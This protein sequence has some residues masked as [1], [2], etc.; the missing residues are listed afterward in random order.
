M[1]RSE[2]QNEYKWDLSDLYPDNAEWE[3]E[4]SALNKEIVAVL[5][6]KGRLAA[7]ENLLQCLSLCDSLGERFERLYCYAM[8]MR[9]SDA[10]DETAQSYSARAEKLISEFNSLSAFISPELSALDESEIDKFIKSPDFAPYDYMLSNILRGKKHILS[11]AEERILAMGSPT[12]GAFSHIFS[13]ISDVDLP[14]PTLNIDG[15]KQRMTHGRYSLWLQHPDA[16]VRKKAFSGMYGAVGALINT[17]AANF[18]AS[19]QKDNYLAAVRGYPSALDK[20]LFTN[21]VPPVVFDKLVSKAGDNVSTLHDYIA[22]RKK[23]LGVPSLHMYDLYVPMFADAD[24]S[25]DYGDAY[26]LV[27]DGLKPLG[28]EYISLLK[29]AK[30]SRWI[31]VCETENKRSGAYSCGVYGAHPYVLLNY[32]KTAHDIF[33]IAHELGHAMHSHYSSR[34]QPYAKNDYSIFVAEVASTVNEVLLLKHLAATSAD[35]AVKKYLLSYYLDMFRTTLFRQTMFAEFE[36]TVHESEAA[37]EPLT[38]ESV[39]KAYM[40]LNK[41]YY[42]AAVAHDRRIRLEWARIPHFY[43]AFYVYQ[44]ATGLTAAVNIAN[45]VLTGGAGAAAKYKEFLSAGGKKSPY[46]ILK[47]CGVDL[48]ADEPYDIAFG[49]FTDTLAKLERLI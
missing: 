28:P 31:D 5:R 18:S 16:A 19:V 20:A 3:R 49:E 27:L 47:D 26:A 2:V 46:E 4:F 40:R 35:P 7:P 21:D 15:K 1:K 8:F 13:A 9:D 34:V 48:A 32:T 17:I 44:Y 37:G 30:A 24:I 39:S 6:F 43:R 25:R 22:L 41:K 36:R 23:V 42:G 14:F 29:T 33:T 10:L 38:V 45:S 11:A 12:H